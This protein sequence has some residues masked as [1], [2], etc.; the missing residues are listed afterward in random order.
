MHTHGSWSNDTLCPYKIKKHS[1]SSPSGCA[2]S[3]KCFKGS[4]KESMLSQ[5]HLKS[6]LPAFC[7]C[8]LAALALRSTCRQ[9]PNTRVAS[10][11]LRLSS[12]ASTA[13]R[14]IIWRRHRP[15]AAA[16]RSIFATTFASRS[17]IRARS[18]TV[19]R[20]SEKAEEVSLLIRL[21]VAASIWGRFCF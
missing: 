21:A 5:E 6:N 7:R 16:W 2:Q 14:R 9:Q 11:I 3:N 1:G 17:R 10:S 19:C 4:R 8:I 15:K 12:P 18:P 20:H 13:C